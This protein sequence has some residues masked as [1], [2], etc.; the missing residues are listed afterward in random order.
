MGESL[1]GAK[2]TEGMFSSGIVCIYMIELS[3]MGLTE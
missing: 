3:E 1:A 2:T